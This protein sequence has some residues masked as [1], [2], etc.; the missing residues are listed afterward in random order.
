M[1]RKTKKALR[2]IG[3]AACVIAMVI[4]VI[5][6]VNIGGNR[7][8]AFEEGFEELQKIDEKYN[9]SFFA[10]Q[11]NVTMVPLNIIPSMIEDIKAFEKSLSRKSESHDTKTLFLFTDVRKLMLTSQWYF[12]K[13]EELGEEGL[14][15]DE[16]GFSCQEANQIIDA[17]F[18]YNESYTYGLQAEEEL[19]DLLYIYTYY[20]EV[21]S[22]IGI[23]LKKT[24]FYR[25]NLKAI[26]HI[27]LNNLKSLEVYCGITGIRHQTTYTQQFQYDREPIPRGKG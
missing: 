2:K 14:V 12:Q 7:E 5:V 9:T 21:M 24:E 3:G 19:D 13:G 25:S 1:R 11:L 6:L 15:N 16:T 26:R 22:L 20:P 17:A 23:D 8:L 10:E 4:A 27:P 18:Y